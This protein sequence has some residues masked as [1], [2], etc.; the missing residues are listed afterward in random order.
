MKTF[1]NGTKKNYSETKDELF[2][3]FLKE[4]SDVVNA[5]QSSKCD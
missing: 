5:S 4:F 2:E 1:G 3:K